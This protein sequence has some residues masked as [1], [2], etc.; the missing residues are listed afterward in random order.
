MIKINLLPVPEKKPSFTF[1]VVTF[2]VL[3]SVSLVIF[4]I[5]Y[6]STKNRIS[7]IQRQIE[8]KKKQISSLEGTYREYMAMEK[9]KR[10]I[11]KR[12]TV[13]KTIKKGRALPARILYDITNVTKESIWLKSLKKTDAKLTIE[14]RAIEN[15]SVA[16]F[17]E[18]LSRLPYMRNVELVNVE[19][20]VE[21]GLAVRKFV[22]QG[23]IIL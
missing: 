9:D 21:E 13:V 12:L 3:L 16:D 15:E 17:M 2:L 14:G 19:E 7:D 5:S 22:I 11:Q 1:D 4:G 6:Y 10:E 23:D 8:E 20:T 18:Q